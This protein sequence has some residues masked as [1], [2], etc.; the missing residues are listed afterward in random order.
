V[1]RAGAA[2]A[3]R[4]VSG[5]RL[6][7]E[8]VPHAARRSVA[9]ELGTLE[10]GVTYPLGEDRF[11][12][13]HGAD[14]FAFV[15]RLGEAH[16]F[17][18]REGGAVVGTATAVLRSVPVAQASVKAWYLCDYKL[19]SGARGGPGARLLLGALAEHARAICPRGYAVSMDPAEGAN[20]LVALAR[21]FF[22]REAVL[23][24]ALVFVTFDAG[25]WGRARELLAR[26][27]GSLGL[28]SLRGIKD[29]VLASTGRP[30]PLVHVQHGPLGVQTPR[31][32]AA[33]EIAMLARPADDAL[34]ARLFALGAR[35]AGRAS[36]LC[37]GLERADFR[38]VL[39]SDV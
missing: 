19:A 1:E 10:R 7:I 31:E 3:A 11:E 24:P 15:D 28:L 35:A 27:L 5:A 12:I 20:R 17:V 22:G 33:D 25:A 6:T 13:D 34:L 32:I 26:E 29:I 23:G 8:F 37:A 4:D 18:L 30:M 21:R 36:V 16:T 9:A 39:S 14:P 2:L 38:F